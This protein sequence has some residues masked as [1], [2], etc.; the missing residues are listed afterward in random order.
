MR[1]LLAGCLV[2]LAAAT[3]ALAGHRSRPAAAPAAASLRCTDVW[4]G[5]RRGAWS[6]ATNWSRGAVPGER[7]YACLPRGVTAV[8]ANGRYRVGAVEAG[9]ITIRRGTLLVMGTA[10]ASEVADLELAHGVLG[11]PGKLIVT[12]RLRWGR[13]GAMLGAGDTVIGFAAVGV[14]AAGNGSQAARIGGP[15]GTGQPAHS[16]NAPAPACN[17]YSPPWAERCATR[18]YADAAAIRQLW[19]RYARSELSDVYVED[20]QAVARTNAPGSHIRFS[21]VNGRWRI[22]AVR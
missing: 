20:D 8:V 18:H 15:D 3:F 5:P 11:G 1:P 9:G 14:I 16:R 22:R 17:R 10:I 13:A 21:R 7:S 4:V 2:A 6:S 19:A 12:R